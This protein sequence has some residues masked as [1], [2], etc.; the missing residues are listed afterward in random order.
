MFIPAYYRNTNLKEI[1]KFISE[2]SFACLVNTHAGK[3][4]ATHIPMEL[5]L[6]IDGVSILSGHISRANPQWKS[7]SNGETVMAIFQ[8]PH[9]Y[10]SSSWYNHINV[11]TWNY[12]AV[13][14]YGTMRILNDEEQYEKLKAMVNRYESIA[15]KPMD[16]DKMPAEMMDKYMKGIVGFEMSMDKIE[17]KWKMSQ[18]RDDEDKQS[19]ISELEKLKEVNALLVAAEMKKMSKS[20]N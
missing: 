6:N 9:S 2:N 13:H 10:V 16:L 20:G 5:E 12:I 11:P 8:G 17:G 4:W 1:E 19:I 18:N 15:E 14:V 3:P 7:F